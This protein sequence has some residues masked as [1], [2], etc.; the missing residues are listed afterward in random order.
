MLYDAP[1]LQN[2]VAIDFLRRY[3]KSRSHQGIVITAHLRGVPD[4]HY[5]GDLLVGCVGVETVM[6][7]ECGMPPPVVRSVF[8]PTTAQKYV[9]TS[10]APSAPKDDG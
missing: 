3:G 7:T 8:D 5:P 1:H 10:H 4:E 2:S 6:L 9:C